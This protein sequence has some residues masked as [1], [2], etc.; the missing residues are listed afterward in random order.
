MRPTIV[1]A[2]ADSTHI[3][4]PSAMSDL[5]DN[6][7]VDIGH[8]AERVAAAAAKQLGTGSGKNGGSGPSE[9]SQGMVQTVLKDML[10]DIMGPAKPTK[11]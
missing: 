11:S 10:E 9:Q 1:T 7:A 2:S 5:H 8:M 6:A 4:A 3:S